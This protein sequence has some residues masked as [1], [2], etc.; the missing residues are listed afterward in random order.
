MPIKPCENQQDHVD[1]S[2]TIFLGVY[3]PHIALS[4]VWELI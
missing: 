2:A 4:K 3:V 1:C